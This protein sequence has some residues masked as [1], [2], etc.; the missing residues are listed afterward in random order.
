MTGQSQCRSMCMKI[1]S[2]KHFYYFYYSIGLK[3]KYMAN[4]S[5]K[6]LCI[7]KFGTISQQIVSSVIYCA[8]VAKLSTPIF[9]DVYIVPEEI[10]CV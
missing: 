10:L 5:G 9:Y 3:K 7:A 2:S 6:L 4:T 1:G 8:V